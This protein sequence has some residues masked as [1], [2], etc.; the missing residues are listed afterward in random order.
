MIKKFPYIILS[1]F[2]LG[3]AACSDEKENEPIPP[4]G[5]KEEVIVYAGIS[6]STVD[7][8]TKADP[9]FVKNFDLFYAINA[10]TL[11]EKV[12]TEYVSA[13]SFYRTGEYWDDHNGVNGYVNMLGVFPRISSLA[14]DG[15]TAIPWSIQ[16]DQS[17]TT[18]LP[19]EDVTDGYDASD[20]HISEQFNNYMLSN[21]KD[22]DPLK[23]KHVMA[24]VTFMLIPGKG[25]IESDEAKA[26]FKPK[27]VLKGMSTG[28]TVNAYTHGVTSLTGSADITPKVL[29]P[30]SQGNVTAQQVAAIL[31]PGQELTKTTVFAQVTI[32][33]DTN[34]NVYDIK[35]PASFATDKL[36]LGQ[37]YNH[38]IKITVHKTDVGLQATVK[39]WDDDETPIIS[40]IKIDL[41]ESDPISGGEDVEHGALLFMEVDN[42]KNSYRYNENATGEEIDWASLSTIFWDDVNYNAP[43]GIKAQGL[44]YNINTTGNDYASAITENPENIYVGESQNL[45]KANDVLRFG[46]MTHPFSKLNI[47]VQSHRTDDDRVAVADIKKITL[48]NSKKFKQ[49]NTNRAVP[50]TYMTIDYEASTENNAEYTYSSGVTPE[51]KEDYNVF[52]MAA[53]IEPGKTFTAN[54]DPSKSDLLMTVQVVTAGI[55][56]DYI[57][58]MPSGSVTFEANKEYNLNVTLKKTSVALVITIAPW[59]GGTIIDDDANIGIGIE[60]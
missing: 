35:L 57:L 47:K 7:V 38:I 51:P 53:Y 25:F 54:A 13:S 3:L 32:D 9:S 34:G 17:K 15:L 43:T 27:V 14:I 40:E 23:F 37:G 44:L 22:G 18:S 56:N 10:S 5:E 16:T 29:E 12:G 55:T 50:A 4:E 36:T 6:T 31:V 41:L 60:E 48:H 33:G 42:Q 1:F 45:K 28:A 8:Q 52:Q 46:Q 11:T 21:Q 49:V 30:V 20:L 26:A 19:Y 59:V 58:R 39:E 2:L 24:K